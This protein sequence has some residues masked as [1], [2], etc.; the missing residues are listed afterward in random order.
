MYGSHTARHPWP[1]SLSVPR[2]SLRLPAA[3]MAPLTA[4]SSQGTSQLA[5]THCILASR[6]PPSGRHHPPPCTGTCSSASTVW[7]LLSAPSTGH[8]QCVLAGH[9]P[10]PQH[11]PG[12]WPQQHTRTHAHARTHARTRTWWKAPSEAHSPSRTKLS[13]PRAWPSTPAASEPST[14]APPSSRGSE[15][16]DSSA[17]LRAPT[18]AR[19]ACTPCTSPA[20]CRTCRTCVRVRQACAGGWIGVRSA[21]GG[22]SARLQAWGPRT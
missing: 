22:A 13:P 20:A 12:P 8:P 15:D 3:C 5:A 21:L 1:S 9:A 4:N 7:A 11:A 19:P 18:P 14:L 17:A 6:Q 10:A 16:D 2:T